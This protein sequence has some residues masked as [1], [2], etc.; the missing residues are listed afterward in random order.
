MSAPPLAQLHPMWI[1]LAILAPLA[2]GLA[3][4]RGWSTPGWA[5]P[6]TVVA[7]VV[8]AVLGTG[9]VELPTLEDLPLEEIVED[10]GDALGDWAYLL[11]GV[12]AF[13]ETG[14]FVGLLAPGETF[15]ILAGVLAGEGTLEVF[16]LLAIVWACAFAGDLVS[17]LLGRRLGRSFLER[18]G[19]RVKIT[20]ERLVQVEAFFD[21]HG[22]KAIIIGRF[23]GFVRAVAPFVLGSSGVS[24]RRFVPYSI[25]GSGM[26][27]TLFVLLGYV[28]WR[29]LDQLLAWAKQGAFVFGTI[30]TVV[31][32]AFVAAHWLSEPEHRE[33]ARAWLEQAGRTRSG[34]VVLAIWRPISGPARFAWGR[35]TPG[36]L[37]LELT[38][39]TA[40]AAVGTFAFVATENLLDQHATTRGDRSVLRI[41]SEID[42][43]PVTDVARVGLVLGSPW[44]VGGVAALTVLL[45]IVRRAHLWAAATLAA[46]TLAGQLA[47]A[48][49]RDA[50]SR[51][52]PAGALEALE[53]SSFPSPVA[54]AAVVWVAVAIA[55]A[56]A[57]RRVPGRIGLTGL[58][59]ILAVAI[60][61]APLALRAAHLSDVLAG[62]GLSVAAMAAVAALGLVVSHLR[63][64]PSG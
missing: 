34:R 59:V 62:A 5:L 11:V 1:A 50:E 15:V 52:Q 43:G 46:A 10:I 60:C 35:V 14:A 61:C 51:P 9:L 23:I 22:G 48:I 57:V 8:G 4:R 54:G 12:L 28:F 6:A 53:G 56:P 64:N 33:Q 44:V 18:H 7:V 13:L 2:L 55:L 26:W 32:G 41:A 36:G 31:V 38:T 24:A 39:L 3:R 20:P 21:K 58:S 29:S 16:T 17:F 27:A 45:L 63:H 19:P 42:V 40:I 49:A 37:G 25:V 30:V 47:V